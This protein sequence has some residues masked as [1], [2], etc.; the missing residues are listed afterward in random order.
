MSCYNNLNISEIEI[1]SSGGFF[2]WNGWNSYYIDTSGILYTSDCNSNSI[3]QFHYGL[4]R[5]QVNSDT[6]WKDITGLGVRKN[7]NIIYSTRDSQVRPAGLYPS[8]D[9]RPGI[10]INVPS[11]PVASLIQSTQNRNI[12]LSNIVKET[13]TLSDGS[14]ICRTKADYTTDS[15]YTI[16]PGDSIGSSPVLGVDGSRLVLQGDYGTNST[17]YTENPSRNWKN[18]WDPGGS[19]MSNK[20]VAPGIRARLHSTIKKYLYLQDSNGNKLINSLQF[21]RKPNVSIRHNNFDPE[22]H[23][24]FYNDG[25]QEILDIN[26]SG[27]IDWLKINNPG[28]GYTEPPSV[29]FIPTSGEIVPPVESGGPLAITKINENGQLIDIQMV[30]NPRIWKKPPIILFETKTNY[31]PDDIFLL[32]VTK[33][34]RTVNGN[35]VTINTDCEGSGIVA[36]SYSNLD[37][38]NN[39]DFIYGLS[40]R[41]DAAIGS[42]I[43]I[44]SGF[45]F[46][47][48]NPGFGQRAGVTHYIPKES[49]ILST[50]DSDYGLSKYKNL[51]PTSGAFTYSLV[52]GEG[53]DYNH[54]FAIEPINNCNNAVLRINNRIDYEQYGTGYY[55]SAGR[56]NLP[57]RI[58]CADSGTDKT[59]GLSIEKIFFFDVVNINEP[60]VALFLDNLISNLPENINTTDR[61]KLADLFIID[62]NE[63]T[64]IPSN[65]NVF[66]ITSTNNDASFFEI[67]GTGNNRSLYLKANT[68]LDYETKSLYSISINATDLGRTVSERYFL[69]II[70]TNDIV[71]GISLSNVIYSLPENTPI[72]NKIKV[73]DIVISDDLLGRNRIWISGEDDELFEIDNYK[74]YFKASTE[75]FDYDQRLDAWGTSF[76]KSQ[77]DININVNDISVEPTGSQTISIPYTLSITNIFDPLS[78]L[79]TNND[80]YTIL[81]D[82]GYV[83]LNNNST[84]FRSAKVECEIIGSIEGD[85]IVTTSGAGYSQANIGDLVVIAQPASGDFIHFIPNRI[86]PT[87]PPTPTNSITPTISNTPTNTPTTTRTPTTTPSNTF[88]PTPSKTV[89]KTPTFSPTNT[90]TCTPTITPTMSQTST[91]TPTSSITHSYTATISPTSSN[92]PS[93]SLTNSKPIIQST[94]N[95]IANIL[96]T[97]TSTPSRAPISTPTPT[98]TI[99]PTQTLTNSPTNTHKATPTFSPTFS[100]TP[101][102]SQTVSLSNSPTNTPSW[103]PSSSLTPSTTRTPNA[104]VT[105]TITTS[106]TLSTTPTITITPSPTMA[107][108]C[109][110]GGLYNSTIFQYVLANI[111]LNPS[112]ITV[113]MAM[114]ITS[115]VTEAV[116]GPG[117]NNIYS[118]SGFLSDNLSHITYHKLH[119]LAPQSDIYEF[120][121][122]KTRTLP[123][124]ETL[125]GSSGIA[126]ILATSGFES[127]ILYGPGTNEQNID[128]NSK[129]TSTLPLNVLQTLILSL[130]ETGEE[131]SYTSSTY[132]PS[133]PFNVSQSVTYY[134]SAEPSW[135]INIDISQVITLGSFR[136]I[137]ECDNDSKAARFT[138]GVNLTTSVFYSASGPMF[139]DQNTI[140][141]EGG[142][143]KCTITPWD[144]NLNPGIGGGTPYTIDV[145]DA[146]EGD[147]TTWK[148]T[149]KVIG[150][151]NIDEVSMEAKF[152]YKNGIIEKEITN[153]K[154]FINP[155]E[156][157]G[158]LGVNTVIVD[159]EIKEIPEEILN[160]TEVEVEYLGKTFNRLSLINAW[161]GAI[162][163]SVAMSAYRDK[164]Y[165]KIVKSINTPN[166]QD[167]VPSGIFLNNGELTI[168]FDEGASRTYDFDGSIISD[169]M[170]EKDVNEIDYLDYY[171]LVLGVGFGSEPSDVQV[172]GSIHSTLNQFG[173]TDLTEVRDNGIFIPADKVTTIMDARYD[174]LQQY[175][176]GYGH[177]FFTSTTSEKKYKPVD[178]TVT[179]KN[180]DRI[181]KY[182]RDSPSVL[183]DYTTKCNVKS[184][185]ETAKI[186]FKSPSPGQRGACFD[187]VVGLGAQDFTII[188]SFTPIYNPA[189][190]TTEPV[191]LLR[192]GGSYELVPLTD[193]TFTQSAD[194]V[195]QAFLLADDGDFYGYDSNYSISKVGKSLELSDQFGPIEQKTL[196]NRFNLNPNNIAA[197][198]VTPPDN[199]SPLGIG[200]DVGVYL[201]ATLGF[202]GK[203]DEDKGKEYLW[204]YRITGR[205]GYGSTQPGSLIGTN[206]YSAPKIIPLGSIAISHPSGFNNA[207]NIMGVFIQTRSNGLL[208]MNNPILPEK[209]PE[210]QL[211]G[212]RLY[213]LPTITEQQR[214]IWKAGDQKFPSFDLT[215]IF[216]GIPYIKAIASNTG[217][218]TE[219]PPYLDGGSPVFPKGTQTSISIKCESGNNILE[220]ITIDSSYEKIPSEVYH[221]ELIEPEDV[222]DSI[223]KFGPLYYI[224]NNS[225]K[226]GIYH[227]ETNAYREVIGKIYYSGVEI[228]DPPCIKSKTFKKII[229]VNHS[230]TVG[231][232][233]YVP[234]TIQLLDNNDNLYSWRQ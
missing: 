60:P 157:L 114:P 119:I 183:L 185:A 109:S 221:V 140:E 127:L 85:L 17:Y 201:T 193:K 84:L 91:C 88:T 5:C 207:F 169:N 215:P 133:G 148:V 181:F 29:I 204:T 112:D 209:L 6:D 42:G 51:T 231:N 43:A 32:Q 200:T 170:V 81:E 223:F 220:Y 224:T 55:G 18:L 80:I 13:I 196:S 30:Q 20:G 4:D 92:S 120:E 191:G 53:S 87:P 233:I 210:I 117:T 34:Q 75:P 173:I 54:L 151:P 188:K 2:S 16:Q 100:C 176:V 50:T 217:I 189:I 69:N 174:F 146:D 130:K 158:S 194:A 44:I 178:R 77:Y 150:S 222:V 98:N 143:G 26:W 76:T 137:V 167:F 177:P 129:P 132:P 101:S 14:I 211:R 228:I 165:N 232:P 10:P 56:K 180:K 153:L 172:N 104:S 203:I 199:D 7:N 149:A 97:P 82:E 39:S 162:C 72:L 106:I 219:H 36:T 27:S 142:N 90:R 23:K 218:S 192:A 41:E 202:T 226:S 124:G 208:F 128:A 166:L 64:V 171:K 122:F 156:V 67:V 184:K 205:P 96:P 135:G 230:I 105:P 89:T 154:N 216:S 225:V 74:L 214:G 168:N 63:D 152:T 24:S 62:D 190:Y 58:R 21:R 139:I 123:T 33:E 136:D 52:A 71:S 93:P 35:N 141:L 107:N 138:A 108:F 46:K 116:V 145:F 28:Y 78:I 103:T 99:S 161:S 31:P 131:K 198:F 175:S 19:Y 48:S 57:I 163:E 118:P 9:F 45:E 121:P 197:C 79:N 94:A 83:S 11:T 3:G 195:N 110:R 95:N 160:S 40:I 187:A 102:F 206:Y 49:A 186:Y 59:A 126:A 227:F 229:D 155:R 212:N 68:A 66:T 47:T 164:Y 38:L 1:K 179:F 147:S 86:L 144:G 115:Q 12:N 8:T 25:Q 134:G 213:A 70:N 65:N 182:I 15:G 125:S 73:A 234:Y 111:E 113:E 61:I 22:Y 37:I 159:K